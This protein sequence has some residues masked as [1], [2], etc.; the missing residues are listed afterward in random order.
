MTNGGPQ[1]ASG[2][3]AR[4]MASAAHLAVF[5]ALIDLEN[6]ANAFDALFRALAAVLGFDRALVL[7]DTDGAAYCVAAQ[8]ADLAGRRWP[9]R[10]LR[11]AMTVRAFAPGSGAGAQDG[12]LAALADGRPA[13]AL[14]IGLGGRPALLVLLRAPAAVGYDESD[15]ALARHYA[16]FAL[17]TVI[18][19]T[20]SR[21]EA[22][23]ARLTRLVDDSRRDEQEARQ[24]RAL[25]WEII[26]HLPIGLTVQDDAGRFILANATAAE[27]LATPADSLIGASP[28]D[29][30][31]EQDAASRREWEL[32]ILRQGSPTTTETSVSD[33]PGARTWV[34]AHTPVRIRDHTLLVSSSVDIT[35]RKEVERA[36]A[37]QARRDELTGLPDR[38]VIEERIAAIIARGE[39][40]HR[41]ALAFIDI[42]NFKHV[43]DYYS[44][45]IGDALL[46]TIARRIAS[47][48][49]PGD[50]LARIS[51]DEFLLVLDPLDDEGGMRSIIDAIL[52]SLKEPVRI[53][54]FEIFSAC[55]IGVCV[56]PA[57]GRSYAELQR[58]AD[59]A[60][61]R[62]K[63]TAR[64]SAV[65][66]DRDMGEAMSARVAVEQRLRLAIRDRHFGCAFQPKVDIHS[67][68]VVGFETLIRWRDDNGEIR[69]PGEFIGLAVEL[70]LI[71]PITNF[72]LA[73]A[74][75]AIDRL[76]AA[77][78]SGTTI[79]IN[80]A[81]A[82]AGDLDFMHSFAQTLRDSNRADR[83]IV[84]VTEDAFVA[85]GTFQTQ[86][87]PILR[88]LGV[89]I[90]IDDFGTGYSSLGM[91]ADIIA[92]EIKIDR[93]FITGINE[94]PRN[95]SVLRAIESL[96]RALGMTIVAEGVETF[97]E[98]AYL[99][100]ATRIRYA[101][102]FYF[103]RPI[104]LDELAGARAADLVRR[105]PEAMRG[106]PERETPARVPPPA[107]SD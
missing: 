12:L 37:D 44:R 8:P 5:A 55:S 73:E 31:S 50:M 41:F 3:S 11:D 32:G 60:M 80:V 79:S 107:R 40:D 53:E 61:D 27:S 100:T 52:A 45:A 106:Q 104:Y 74:L 48:L 7:A 6:D 33:Q 59:G 25:L 24:D 42:D 103:S 16:A 98:L 13:L 58:N 10:A 29:F 15:L 82:Q 68:Q 35:D 14:P 77:F 9:G 36:L 64:G 28:A 86:V 34:T 85:K 78:G 70:G 83:I 46:V 51:G 1:A 17:S 97:E 101:Q 62:A 38:S 90:S 2:A 65:F 63:R 94:R 69:A 102:G 87:L 92:D 67:Q 105:A 91:L 84:E 18:A 26:D 54:S 72:V 57:H 49:R 81:A 19:R 76:D 95:Q 88:E 66:F 20:G 71:N 21:L 4:A 23:V 22:E 56:Y 89:R 39:P 43:N 75:G 47:R 30:L 93:S 99:Q 96:G